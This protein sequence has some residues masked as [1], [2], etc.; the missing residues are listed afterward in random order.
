MYIKKLIKQLFI[1]S[2]LL[3]NVSAQ[4]ATEAVPMKDFTLK[5]RAGDNVRL[6]ELSGDVI[7]INFW[8]SWC[9]P[10][11]KELPKLEE[12]HQKYKDLGV[13]ILGI[14]IDANT[15]LSK[16]LLKEFPVNFT[17]LYDPE[18]TVSDDYEIQSMPS[19]FL[20]DKKALFRY[21]HNGYLPGY[22]DKY[23]E[24]IKQLLRE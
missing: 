15:E 6:K 1:V 16:K 22:E 11:R 8:A 3:L 2:L 18:N 20:V 24:Q 14:N 7:V 12:L 4:A 5:S 17:I 19:T 21:R 13:T 9:G 23:D 10:C